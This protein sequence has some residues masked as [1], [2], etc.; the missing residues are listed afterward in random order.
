MTAFHLAGLAPLL[1][2]FILAL[3]FRRA[4][5]IHILVIAYDAVLAYIAIVDTWELLFFPVLAIIAIIELILFIK[6][7]I[8]GAWI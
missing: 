8:E 1:V 4:G 6:C 5:L 2:I 7:A 3:I